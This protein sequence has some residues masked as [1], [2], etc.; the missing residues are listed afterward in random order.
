M[1]LNGIF[2]LQELRYL[3]LVCSRILLKKFLHPF[4]RVV[5]DFP[6]PTLDRKKRRT[7][8]I[9]GFEVLA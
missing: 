2:A 6:R 8:C 5:V 3:I 9:E 1:Y 7:D 4:L